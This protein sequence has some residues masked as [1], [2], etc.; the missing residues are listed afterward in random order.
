VA[1]GPPAPATDTDVERLLGTD[2]EY[3]DGAA[4]ERRVLARLR[5]GL[6]MLADLRR[7]R[8]EAVRQCAESSDLDLRTM[9][10]DP[11]LRNAFETDL[12][13]VTAH[14]DAGSL[15]PRYLPPG[16]G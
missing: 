12:Q 1:G 8:S 16:G 13:S 14:A 11:V 9:S 15:L 5:V 7:E 4:I 6:T 10:H 2:P 3:G